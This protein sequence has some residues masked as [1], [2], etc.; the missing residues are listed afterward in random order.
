[1]AKSEILVNLMK[2]AQ[3]ELEQLAAGLN[4]SERNVPG[5][6][7]RWS[8]KDVIGHLGTW[9]GR[10]VTEID[11]VEGGGKL[12]EWGDIDTANLAIFTQNAQKSWDEVWADME[13]CSQAAIQR[14][15]GVSDEVLNTQ[16][17]GGRSFE[18]I[19]FGNTFIHWIEHIMG[20]YLER[21][22]VASAERL[23]QLELRE[24][25]AF[26]PTPRTQAIAKYNTA[27]FY[28]K[29][30]QPQKAVDLLREV[31]QMRLDL[32]DWAKQDGDL[33]SLHDLQEF[34]ELFK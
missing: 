17:E 12:P 23:L 32:R 11:D 6:P 7:D 4:E 8:V 16:L 27:C 22:D 18:R 34:E 26:D 29:T 13:R 1:M 24:L 21:G 30:R 28:A 25:Q 5:L 31:F 33:V 20:C 9:Q 19:I 10:L 15:A 3:A 14:T 2:T